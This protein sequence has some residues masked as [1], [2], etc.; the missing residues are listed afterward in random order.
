MTST[1]TPRSGHCLHDL[2]ALYAEYEIEITLR[3]SVWIPHTVE[4]I[5]VFLLRNLPEVQMAT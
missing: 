4:H 1:F 5:R 3:E 2:S